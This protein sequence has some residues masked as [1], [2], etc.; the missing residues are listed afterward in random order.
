MEVQVERHLG[1]LTE[2]TDLC[3]GLARVTQ[4]KAVA[5]AVAPE[6]PAKAGKADPVLAFTRVARAV[7]QTIALEAQL[8]EDH[9]TRG[10]K[11]ETARKQRAAAARD[12]HRAN[13]LD[14]VERVVEATLDA[15]AGKDWRERE[16]LEDEFRERLKD[17]DDYAHCGKRPIG[18]IIARICRDLGVTP[19]WARWV[20]AA[21]AGDEMATKPPGSPYAAWPPAPDHRP[22]APARRAAV[23]AT[24]PP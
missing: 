10:E 5:Q 17:F 15:K 21:W 1:I 2:L 18:E 12:E 7:R 11:T 4:A 16:R 20:D 9:R 19:D 14:K 6:E 3:M 23:A 24:G 8:A 22:V 13:Q